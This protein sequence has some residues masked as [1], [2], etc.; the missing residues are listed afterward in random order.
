MAPIVRFCSSSRWTSAWRSR[1]RS[2]IGVLGSSGASRSITGS[3]GA[4]SARSAAMPSLWH[5]RSPTR[6]PNSVATDG[7]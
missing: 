6:P 5:S 4:G 2:T 3:S 1:V 7:P